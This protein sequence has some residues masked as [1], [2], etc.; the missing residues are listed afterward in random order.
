MTQSPSFGKL[1]PAAAQ[2]D[3]A[4]SQGETLRVPSPGEKIVRFCPPWT[5]ERARAHHLWIL[6]YGFYVEGY[7]PVHVC[8]KM[9]NEDYCPGCAAASELYDARQEQDDIFHKAAGAIRASNRYFWNV[10]ADVFQQRV[11]DASGSPVI[12]TDVRAGDP[13]IKPYAAGFTTHN[14]LIMNMSD[15]GDITDPYT[16]NDVKLVRQ[17]SGGQSAEYAATQVFV[18]PGKSIVS[19]RILNR[20]QQGLPELDKLFEPTDPAV[21]REI[22]KLYVERKFAAANRRTHVGVVNPGMPAQPYSAQPYSPQIPG[23][24]APQVQQQQGLHMP[25][26][27]QAPQL[28]APAL[29]AGYTSPT[30]TLPVAPSQDH[31]GTVP[32]QLPASGTP[33]APQNVGAHAQ[34]SAVPAQVPPAQ[35]PVVPSQAPSMPQQQSQLTPRVPLQPAPPQQSTAPVVPA[36][37]PPPVGG[38][39]RQPVGAVPQQPPTTVLPQG[40]VPSQALDDLEQQLTGGT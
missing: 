1:D 24:V 38:G 26:L 14:T 9:L 3:L 21:F 8:T 32:A 11:L 15:H 30:S 13:V 39:F 23:Q 31:T 27:P 4:K 35:Q 37:A 33:N 17:P 20:M 2:A 40:A 6:H 18:L 7:K 16:G 10:V 22:A 25:G 34:E 28:P 29:P 5:Q 19:Q 12:V 36:Q